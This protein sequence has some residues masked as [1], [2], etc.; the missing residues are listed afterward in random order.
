MVPAGY[1]P[2]ETHRSDLRPAV[3][4]ALM[5]GL[6]CLIGGAVTVIARTRVLHPEIT[7][8]HLDLMPACVA[9]AVCLVP[10]VG[11]HE[12]LHALGART[13]GIPW[14][15]IRFGLSV[16][17]RMPYVLVEGGYTIGQAA[18]VF[19]VPVVVTGLFL[20]LLVVLT[21]KAVAVVLFAIAM[22]IS[23]ADVIGLW[24]MRRYCR[25]DYVV[26]GDDLLTSEIYRK[27]EYMD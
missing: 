21:G 9:V 17:Y 6:L 7:S 10:L 13:V 24:E 22:G 19:A 25:D 11:A 26:V 4:A 20:F 14:S 12:V 15:R 27:A 18:I 3:Q 16:Q 23:M 5:M 2:L 8:F 1:E